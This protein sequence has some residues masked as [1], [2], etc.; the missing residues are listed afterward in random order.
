MMVSN[1]NLLFQ[2]SIFRFHVC[3]GG[4]TLYF[5]YLL[6][7]QLQMCLKPGHWHSWSWARMDFQIKKNIWPWHS[8][9]IF[10]SNLWVI[11][12]ESQEILSQ[13]MWSLK[14][15]RRVSASVLPASGTEVAFF[16][17][18]KLARVAAICAKLSSNCLAVGFCCNLRLG[19]GA[20]AG[21]GNSP[22]RGSNS[23]AVHK[24]L[25]NAW[26]FLF[27]KN[28]LFAHPACTAAP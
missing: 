2:G 4:C 6:S 20:G 1:R 10:L 11:G 7:S 24:A 16:N 3:F 26:D 13:E 25:S 18:S 23:G 12:K 8:K 5:A 22:L 21:G 17:S 14:I 28:L 19:A 27:F 15:A 9:S